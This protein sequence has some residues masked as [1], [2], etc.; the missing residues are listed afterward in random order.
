MDSV[1]VEQVEVTRVIKLYLQAFD[2]EVYRPEK[3]TFA[4]TYCHLSISGVWHP[5]PVFLIFIEKARLTTEIRMI[6]VL[7]ADFGPVIV[8]Q[9]GG[10]SIFYK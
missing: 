9:A 6:R 1:F 4:V 3:I 10:H 7:L 5:W 2:A 8:Y